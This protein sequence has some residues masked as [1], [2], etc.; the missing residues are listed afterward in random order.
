MVLR[1][2]ARTYTPWYVLRDPALHAA[3]LFPCWGRHVALS[4]VGAS[5]RVSSLTVLS[6]FSGARGRQARQP[7]H[8][9][10]GGGGNS[11]A[12]QET[13]EDDCGQFFVVGSYL[14]RIPMFFALSPVAV[15]FV[16]DI[17]VCGSLT[18]RGR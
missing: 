17:D 5:Q 13:E 3:V 6:R 4:F 10:G 2:D 12:D 15:V 16:D 18:E 7:A 11:A 14:A 1:L 9:V 8:D